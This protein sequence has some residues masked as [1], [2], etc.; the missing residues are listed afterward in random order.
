MITFDK[1]DFET[2]DFKEGDSVEITIEGTVNKIG[3]K[4]EISPINIT[5]LPKEIEEEVAPA[6]PTAEDEEIIKE[7]PK[8]GGVTPLAEEEIIGDEEIG[9]IERKRRK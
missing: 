9:R 2:I 1:K 6:T 3:N 4:I 8:R 5:S 7:P